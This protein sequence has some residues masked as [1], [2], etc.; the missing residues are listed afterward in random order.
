[1]R[2]VNNSYIASIEKPL[3]VPDVKDSDRVLK[4]ITTADTTVK[5]DSSRAHNYSE[6]KGTLNFP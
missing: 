5:Y 6:Q 2:S 1:M 4:N 3:K